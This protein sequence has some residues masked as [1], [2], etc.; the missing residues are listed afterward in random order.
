M[1]VF[2]CLLTLAACEVREMK[3]ND[4]G[5]IFTQFFAWVAAV[6]S[7]IGFTTQDL[8]F[9]STG[10]LMRIAGVKRTRSEQKWSMTT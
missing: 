5:N 9:T 4:S 10:V 1:V 2:L 8:V 7:A 3:M 6:A